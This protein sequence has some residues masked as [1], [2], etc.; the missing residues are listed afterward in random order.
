MTEAYERMRKRGYSIGN[1]D[2]TLI[3]QKPR[4]NVEHAGGQVKEKMIAKPVPGD[5]RQPW[6]GA[7]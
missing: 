3:C 1:V 4:V 5:P 2:I 7:W 6:R